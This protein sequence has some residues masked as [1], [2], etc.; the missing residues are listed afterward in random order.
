MGN[1]SFYGEAFSQMVEASRG[2]AG[3]PCVPFPLGQWVPD[4]VPDRLQVKQGAASSPSGAEGSLALGPGAGWRAIAAVSGAGSR[5]AHPAL[6]HVAQGL[7]DPSP[8]GLPQ[9]LPLC[10]SKEQAVQA[11]VA[12]RVAAAPF[13]FP[14]SWGK[15]V[16]AGVGGSLEPPEPLKVGAVVVQSA[17][18]WAYG[19]VTVAGGVAGSV[20]NLP[21][22]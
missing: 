12:A 2:F 3:D 19:K 11:L 10:E 15:L 7:W 1:E 6:R 9:G 17:A 18:A 14:V 21:A 13:P 4:R 20:S 16:P 5:A 22:S 8:G